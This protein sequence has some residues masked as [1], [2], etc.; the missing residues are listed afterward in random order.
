MV[1]LGDGTGLFSVHVSFSFG[2]CYFLP[3][4]FS[5]S[6]LCLMDGRLTAWSVGIAILLSNILMYAEPWRWRW[7]E[8]WSHI[9]ISAVAMEKSSKRRIVICPF[10]Q[11]H[12]SIYSITFFHP[13]ACAT[14]AVPTLLASCNRVIRIRR[15]PSS[16]IAATS[17][18]VLRIPE[19][20]PG[21]KAARV[22][23]RPI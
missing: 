3:I 1:A 4:L 12:S 22:P 2:L 18:N 16:P 23:S 11:S 9:Y 13:A 17:R 10:S 5:L 19:T 14:R 7:H 21:D 20:K 8:G 15:S 6:A